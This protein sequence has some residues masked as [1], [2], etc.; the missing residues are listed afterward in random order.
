MRQTRQVLASS[1][2]APYAFAASRP[3]SET[4]SKWGWMLPAGAVTRRRVT[5][6]GNL[7]AAGSAT[8]PGAAPVRRRLPQRPLHPRP[9]AAPSSDALIGALTPPGQSDRRSCGGVNT[10][11]LEYAGCR[12]PAFGAAPGTRA[13]A[14]RLGLL[15]RASACCREQ[16]EYVQQPCQVLR[17]GSTCGHRSAGRRP[18]CRDAQRQQGRIITAEGIPHPP[19]PSTDTATAHPHYSRSPGRRHDPCCRHP[20]RPGPKHEGH[21]GAEVCSGSRTRSP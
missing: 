18:V 2:N 1:D 5:A 4:I 7:P 10:C 9:S 14:L 17:T 19:D 21:Y 12:L 11:G 6:A 20:A 3:H 16:A 8:A 15:R 13:T